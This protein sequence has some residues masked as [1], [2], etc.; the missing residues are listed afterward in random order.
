MISSQLHHH[1]ERPFLA[2]QKSIQLRFEKARPSQL[3][4][5]GV[6]TGVCPLFLCLCRGDACGRLL[7]GKQGPES[8][9]FSER[10]RQAAPEFPYRAD[11]VQ[12]G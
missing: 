6:L 3:L 7:H 8:F 2:E 10:E 11:E 4:S 1:R 9:V 12:E 5:V